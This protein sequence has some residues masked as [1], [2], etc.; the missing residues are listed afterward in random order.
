[1]RI[2][3]HILDFYTNASIHVALSVYALTWITLLEFGISYDESVLYFNFFGTITGY[4]FVKYFGL[5]KFHHRSLANWL[6]VIQLFSLICFVALCYYAFQLEIKTWLYILVL[7]AI[8][9]FYAIPFLPR[10]VFVDKHHNLRQISGLKIYVIGLVWSGVTVFLP[11]IDNEIPLTLDV[12]ITA[13]QRFV[14]VLV[15]MIPFEIRDLRYDSLKLSTIPQRIGV[16]KTKIIGIL[17]VMLFFFSEFFKDQIYQ[18][19][20]LILLVF[21]FILLLFIAFSRENQG[22]YYSAFWV[23]GLPILWLILVLFYGF[24]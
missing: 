15:L 9:F 13:F 5:A 17:L 24:G 16:K 1:M 4:N 22:K 20:T 3:K 23:E 6:K 21:T 7:G 12:F 10:N 18:A 8:T 11:I 14:L 19:N 2:L